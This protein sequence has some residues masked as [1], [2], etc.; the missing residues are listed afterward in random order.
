MG[1]NK[2]A[3]RST[4]NLHTTVNRLL[5]SVSKPFRQRLAL[6]TIP[7]KLNRLTQLL[8]LA[9]TVLIYSVMGMAVANSLFVSH[10]GAGQLPFAFI[11]IGLSS[12]PAYAVFSQIVKSV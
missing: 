8:L 11:L 10:V 3:L 6:P 9:A 1:M 4:V 5:S 12:M 2:R 7:W